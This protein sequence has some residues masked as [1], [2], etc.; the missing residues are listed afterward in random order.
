MDLFNNNH[1]E[2]LTLRV[3]GIEL[4]D[5]ELKFV[6]STFRPLVDQ[7]PSNSHFIFTTAANGRVMKGT[8][9]INSELQNFVSETYSS[10]IFRTCTEIKKDI[11]AKMN[12]WR[13]SK[14]FRM[15][16]PLTHRM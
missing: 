12:F 1:N 16:E 4:S 6:V 8:L 9:N 11:Q 7:A 13:D 14:R 15:S 3:R 5:N 10:N 2:W